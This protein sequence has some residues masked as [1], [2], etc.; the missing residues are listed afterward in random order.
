MGGV[1]ESRQAKRSRAAGGQPSPPH[2]AW[3]PNA[4]ADEGKGGNQQE[5]V[6]EGVRNRA[7]INPPQIGVEAGGAEIAEQIHQRKGAQKQGKAAG[8]KAPSSKPS[9]AR[10]GI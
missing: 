8:N 10:A 2:R 1:R 9:A 4:E 3:R 7:K 5:G 6:G